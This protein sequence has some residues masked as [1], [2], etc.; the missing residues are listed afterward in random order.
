MGKTKVLIGQSYT[1][2]PETI[3]LLAAMMSWIRV[4]IQRDGK[5]VA[6]FLIFLGPMLT[7]TR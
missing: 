3:S 1:V 2:P 6:D 7:K 4:S 5:K